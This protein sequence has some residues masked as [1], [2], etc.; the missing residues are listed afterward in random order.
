MLIHILTQNCHAYR[1]TCFT[2]QYLSRL[3]RRCLEMGAELAVQRRYR[4]FPSFFRNYRYLHLI[5]D[6]IFEPPI[7]VSCCRL[8][9][10][11]LPA[12]LFFGVFVGFKK[13]CEFGHGR[14]S[15]HQRSFRY[16]FYYPKKATPDYFEVVFPQARECT[17]EGVTTNAFIYGNPQCFPHPP[18]SD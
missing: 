4:E 13:I 8:L 3:R 7:M 12:S 5:F 1:S 6:R 18:P 9:R 17:S 16:R 14:G 2:R 15:R 11:S 10:W